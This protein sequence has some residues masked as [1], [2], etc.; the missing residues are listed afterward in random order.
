MLKAF[1]INCSC[2]WRYFILSGLPISSLPPL[3]FENRLPGFCISSLALLCD[4]GQVASVFFTC[5]NRDTIVKS[6]FLGF[7]RIKCTNIFEVLIVRY[8][9]GSKMLMMSVILLQA[10]GCSGAMHRLQCILQA[11]RCLGWGSLASVSWLLLRACRAHSSFS[12]TT[13]PSPEGQQEDGV[14]KDFGSRLAAGPTFQHF[15]RSA[16]VP[17]EKLSSP[18]V[19]DPPPYLTVDELLG[20]HRKG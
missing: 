8:T 9:Q 2:M 19:V 14:Q 12:T 1:G 4:I 11:Q 18:D 16:S 20:R 15:L 3:C 17:P 6:I 13:C 7:V 10:L 5:K